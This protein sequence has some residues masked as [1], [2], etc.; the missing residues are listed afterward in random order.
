M[1][2]APGGLA[3]ALKG[4]S[5][6]HFQ[7][8]AQSPAHLWP[9]R[10]G[11]VDFALAATPDEIHKVALGL[12]FD[13]T[14]G[15]WLFEGLGLDH[16]PEP[17]WGRWYPGTSSPGWWRVLSME[18]RPQRQVRFHGL[19]PAEDL[20]PGNLWLRA[21]ANGQPLVFCPQGLEGNGFVIAPELG[22]PWTD[23]EQVLGLA[24]ALTEVGWP[25]V[26]PSFNPHEADCFR[27]VFGGAFL[28]GRIL[29]DPIMR[30]VLLAGPVVPGF[31]KLPGN[32]GTSTPCP[33]GRKR[34]PKP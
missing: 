28:P 25:G 16:Q 32:E 5:L 20:T 7:F 3:L 22:I 2:R 27:R 9:T 23:K 11:L 34:Q 18:G 30:F 4:G 10:P 33:K 13:A 17:S 26:F 1:V 31:P 14:P 12:D 8:P 29:L 21:L 15:P 24:H 19:L 6:I